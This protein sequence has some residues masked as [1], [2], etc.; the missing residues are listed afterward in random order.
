[1]DKKQLYT[2]FEHAP[3]HLINLFDDI[4]DCHSIWNYL[5]KDI[6]DHHI[7][8]RKAKIRSNSL[9]W[10]DSSIRKEMN[11]RFKLLSEA[12]ASGDS[13]KWRQ[14]REKR[15]KVKSLL[16]RAEAAYWK[17][18]F[19]KSTNPKEFWK[20]TN[21]VLRK[22]KISKLGPVM[23]YND[24][25]LTD[26]LTK[27]E[28]FNDFFIN[29]TESLT[30]KLNP[31]DE[32]TL[33]TFV[34]RI[35]PTKDCSDIDWELVR[36]ITQKVTNP[37]KAVGPDLV[38]PKDLSLVPTDLVIHS[39]LPLHKNSL[40]SASFPCDWKL[41]RVTPLFKKGKPSDV[42][43]YRPIS[44]LSIPGKILESVVCNSINDHLQSHNL[45][46]RNQWGFRK[47]HSTEGLLL[48][49][50]ETWKSALD[51]GLVVGVL[52]V[53][54]R[55][56]FDSVNHSILLEKLKAIG[57]SGNLFSWLA[58]YLSN[59]N[60][61]VQISGK[62]SALQ[63]VK[64]GVPQGSIL[65]PRLFSIYVNDLPESIS[66]G[67]LYMFAD[68]TTVYTI[69]RDTD[70]II[71]SL[72]CILSQLHVWCSANRLVAHESKTEAMIISRSSF[73]GPLPALRYGTMTI[74]LKSSSKC[75]GLTIDNK[76]SWQEH[77]RNVCNLFNQK[78]AVLKQ[79][80]FLPQSTLESI[81][82]NSIIPSVVY[83]IVVWGSASPS[84]MEDIER[85]HMRAL[86]I[87]CKLPMTTPADEIMK[88]RQWNPISLYYVKRLL[89][90]T[91]RSYHSLNTEDLNTLI[92][93]AKTNY[94]LRNSLNIEV[95]RPR[96]E[97]GR[98]SFKHRAALAWNLLPHHVKECANLRL[99]KIKLKVNKHLLNS[100]NFAKG[101]C[102]V[103]MKHDDF[104]YF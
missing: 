44:L 75:L 32:S 5:Y 74:E 72:Q 41:S 30:T 79:I 83:N 71:S 7:P 50:T 10:I 89:V 47:N 73:I 23:D 45:L 17:E 3:W 42:N 1:M 98:S 102:C 27:A 20:L 91:Y 96:S 84:L 49:M 16:K 94:S 58:N 63:P 104:L 86:R 59:R 60:Q 51:Q 82:F 28:H 62:K 8:S 54:F 70:T 46:S 53:D 37:E 95:P 24:K 36:S 38:S 40:I 68:D 31:L 29:V 12:K 69:G 25:L 80:K 35:T 78:L 76:L 6:M 93:K 13:V 88:L 92:S 97:F 87:V 100:I 52:F 57:I 4:D 2:D 22:N 19:N 90:L 81:Y 26:D 65:G 99:F 14:Y 15:N 43:N 77:I 18:Q 21:Q 55:K 101:S 67:D 34:T 39:L 61:F 9:P 33:S 103:S 11:K 64:Y 48:H 56:A 85:I 66:Y